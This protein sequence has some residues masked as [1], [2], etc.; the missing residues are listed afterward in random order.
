MNRVDSMIAPCGLDCSKCDIFTAQGDPE[1]MRRIIGWFEA[2]RNM[3]LREEDIKCG[4]CPGDRA[5]HWSPDCWIL[6]CT[7]DGRGLRHCSECK[8]FPCAKLEEWATDNAGYRQALE[9]LK[10]MLQRSPAG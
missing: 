10:R 5:K 7:V 6:K 9:R 2:K 3:K 1:T 8:E 4:G